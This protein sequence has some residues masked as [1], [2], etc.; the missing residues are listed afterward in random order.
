MQTSP[1]LVR[2]MALLALT[3]LS[4]TLSPIKAGDGKSAYSEGQAA[5]A[6][7]TKDTSGKTIRFPQDY[8]G[9]VVLLDFWATWC[10]PCR[11]E[12]PNV[13]G[14]YEQ[15]HSQ[16]FE[17]LGVS[18]DR[19]NAAAK[20]ESFTRENKM[21]WPQIYDGRYWEAAL[22]QKYGIHSIP[23]PILVD[24]DT[25]VILAEGPSARGS[26]LAPAIQKALAGKHAK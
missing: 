11:A 14:A 25:G 12:L 9:K 1:I 21:T 7:E 2:G 6:F 22:A 3:A 10:G 16:G 4:T 5:P 24:G 19:A 20:L 8:K 15:F 13:V 23:R 18:L 17:V 26:K